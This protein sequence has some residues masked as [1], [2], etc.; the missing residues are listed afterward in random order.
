MKPSI[1]IKALMLSS[2]LIGASLM[3]QGS[4]IK[5]KASL[6][7]WLIATSWG[8]RGPGQA[9][10]KPWP[11]ADTHVVARLR[12]VRLGIEQFIMQDA[13]G[14]SLAFGPGAMLPGSLPGGPD[15][16]L[17][18][19]HRDTHFKF[20][21]ALKPGD[22]LYIDNYLGQHNRYIVNNARVLNIEQE[23]LRIDP[24][25]PGLTLV[26]CWPFDSLV[27]GGPLRFLVDAE[28][29]DALTQTSANVL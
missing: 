12:A 18:A 22:V 27:P 15:Y 13:S 25:A 29:V 28:Q 17:I 4:Y 11:W 14:E 7:K 19:G 8:Q 10:A 5:L 24:D 9:P 20:L 26:T 6:A 1:L 23:E 3:G 21:S 2:M 16:S